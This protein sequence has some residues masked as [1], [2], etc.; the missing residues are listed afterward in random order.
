ME[1][2][3]LDFQA[4]LITLREAFEALLIVGIIVTYL[5]RVGAH[6]WK[7]WVWFGSFLALVA[8]FFVALLFQVVLTSYTAMASEHF[9]RIGISFAS[10]L[11]LTHMA[12]W[13]SGQQKDIRGEMQQKL[14]KIL[15][16][17]SVANLIIH[18]FLVMLREG[19]ETV[20]FFAAIS[21]GNIQEALSSWGAILGLAVA[22]VLALAF[23]KGSRKISLRTFFT[24]TKILIVVIAA[25][26]LAQGVG[27]LQDYG[28]MGSLYETPAGGIGKVYNLVSILPE[29][30]IDEEHYIRDTG[31]T[32]LI[33]GHVG[34]FLKA[35]FGYSHDPSVEEVLVYWL[36]YM[37]IFFFFRRQAVSTRTGK[38]SN[39]ANPPA[40]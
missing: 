19:V 9:L 5:T 11:L 17:G 7:K 26:L 34:I 27:L 3:G 32:P 33:S 6:K 14:D 13:M 15:T 31:Q 12:V 20:F 22:I 40:A 35:M 2:Q 23:F 28:L 24:A 29:H 39:I 38:E 18:S 21:G 1:L 36:Y 10:A 25:G 8:S 4:F 16:A 37:L 30:P